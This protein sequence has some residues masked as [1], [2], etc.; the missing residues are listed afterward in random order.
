MEG[1][2]NSE[3]I[4]AVE[5]QH[6]IYK[7]NKITPGSEVRSL[8]RPIDIIALDIIDVSGE[9]PKP[10]DTQNW[11]TALVREMPE[12]E[13]ARRMKKY[14]DSFPTIDEA[15]VEKVFLEGI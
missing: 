13:V 2:M 5:K 4:Q 7:S 1:P 15:L 14:R 6:R 8:K 9:K 10:A 12:E 11:L 3:R